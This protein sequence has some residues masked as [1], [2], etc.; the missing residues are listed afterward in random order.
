MSEALYNME[1]FSSPRVLWKSNRPMPHIHGFMCIFAVFVLS[2]RS[3]SR[4]LGQWINHPVDTFLDSTGKDPEAG[5]EGS[6]ECCR[7]RR[8]KQVPV[9]PPLPL[10]KSGQIVQAYKFLRNT[11]HTKKAKTWQ[12][13]ALVR[14]QVMRRSLLGPIFFGFAIFACLLFCLTCTCLT[15]N[16]APTDR[17]SFAAGRVTVPIKK[18][19]KPAL[20]G[21]QSH[22][23]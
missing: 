9:K 13:I 20:L 19:S 2:R 3:S 10:T 15:S 17:P 12:Y 21:R 16:G 8:S 5:P 7:R 22:G 4:W 1:A 6:S 18:K 14:T 23:G 11:N